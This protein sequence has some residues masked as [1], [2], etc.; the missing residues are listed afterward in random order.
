M[1]IRQ[2]ILALL[3]LPIF[4]QLATVGLLWHTLN[5]LD[6]S[7]R[8][9]MEA[10]R[11]VALIQEI[12]GVVGESVTKLTGTN[13]FK[14]TPETQKSQYFLSL[15]DEK[16]NDLRLL[17]GD[18]KKAATAA[19]NYAFHARRLIENWTELINGYSTGH[20]ELFFGQFLSTGEYSE[21][22]KVLIDR[23]NEDAKTLF[24]IYRPLAKELQPKA[25]KERSTLR[26]LIIAAIIANLVLLA[27]LALIVNKQT[28]NRLNELMTHIQSFSTG[29]ETFTPLTGQDELAELDQTFAKMSLERRKLDQLR[30]S[31]R[32]MVNHD[33]RSPL[34][35]IN[36]RLESIAEIHGA[37]LKPLVLDQIN[38]VCS[39]TQRLI[40]LANTL[41]DVDRL[42]DGKL[43][44]DVKLNCV[45]SMVESSTAMISAQA[46]RRN[47]KIELDLEENL[48][49]SCDAD[50]TI[51]VLTNLLSNAMKFTPKNSTIWISACVVENGWIRMEVIDEGEGVPTNKIDDLFTRFKQLDQPEDIKTQG[52]GLGLFICKSLIEAQGGRIGYTAIEGEGGCFWIELPGEREDE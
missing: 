49:V 8:Q 39:E 29:K 32:E 36:L 50:R 52:S 51:Q 45:E 25:I 7:A 24:E 43:D 17:V 27:I 42:E 30:Q 12:Y 18:N 2:Q 41:L 6:R 44:V 40:R 38:Q 22:L 11:V 10:K 35:S 37:D 28:L 26:S 3:C 4:C 19:K 13:F 23:L 9:E 15:L 21:S 16:G 1:K 48:T 47:V 14:L 34:S 31:I 46:E 5:A 20:D 33:M